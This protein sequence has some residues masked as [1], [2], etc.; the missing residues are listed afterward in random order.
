MSKNPLVPVSEDALFSPREIGELIS[1]AFT[2]S[3]NPAWGGTPLADSR[4]GYAR[5]YAKAL[6]E[7]LE[8]TDVATGHLTY[9]ECVA[10]LL[11]TALALQ[12]LHCN[13]D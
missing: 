8:A 9:T 3:C 4:L 6:M 5:N 7:R 13:G 10:M 2:A 11:G 1:N 12:K